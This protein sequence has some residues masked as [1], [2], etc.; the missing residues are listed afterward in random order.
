M[1]EREV[2][3]INRTHGIPSIR[4]ILS[5]NLLRDLGGLARGDLGSHQSMSMHQTIYAGLQPLAMVSQAL[6]GVQAGHIAE[7][8]GRVPRARRCPVRI[9]AAT[10]SD[11]SDPPY[12]AMS[13]GTNPSVSST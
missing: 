3:W 8:T 7:L 2:D 13:A 1:A 5:N 10:R 11:S 9:S 12:V 4:L 6:R